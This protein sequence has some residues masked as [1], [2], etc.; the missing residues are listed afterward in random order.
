MHMTTSNR[1][2]TPIA[3]IGVGAIF[4]GASEI[5][6][7]WRNILAG[8]DLITDVPA[9]HW[10]IDDYFDADPTATDKTYGK[11][12][13]FLPA[14]DFDP[15][16]FGVPPNNIG[17]TDTAQ[18]LALIVAQQVLEDACQGEFAAM[19]RDRVSVVLGVA[20]GTELLCSM[21]SRMQRPVWLKALRESGMPEDEAQ[22]ACDR[23]AA[24]YAPWQEATFPGLLGNVVAGRIANRFDLHGTNCVTD[25]AC[26]SSLSA[27][28]MA[29]NELALG[30]SDLVISGGVDT[31]NDIMMY[32]CFSKTPALSASGD[33]RPFSDEADGTMLGEG[34]GMFALKR[35]DDAERDGDRVYAVIRGLGTSSDGRSTAVYAPLPQGQ[36][37]AIANAYAAAGYGPETVELL[38]AHGTGTKAGDAAEFAGLRDVFAGADPARRQ[39]CALGSVK[40]QI[41]HT[42]ATAG[43]AGLLKA[44]LALHHKVLPPTIKIRQPNPKLDIGASPFYLNTQA[45]PWIRNDAHPRRAGVS[46]FGFGGS[47]FHVTVEEYVPASGAQAQPAWRLRAVPTELVLLS[48][49]SAADL[50]RQCRE[51]AAQP[52]ALDA[53]ARASQAAFDAAAPVR[54]ALVAADTAALVQQ[55]GAAIKKIEQDPATPFSTPLG[56]VYGAAKADPGKIAFLFSGQGS[57]YVGMGADLAQHSPAARRAWDLAAQL[58]FDGKPL[59]SVTFPIPVFSDAEREAQAT[60]LTATE[61]AQPALAAQSLAL[62]AEL[63]ELG[64]QP[65]ALAGHSFGELVALHAAGAMSAD[66]LLRLA[67][68][69]GELMRDAGAAPGAMLAVAGVRADIEAVLAGLQIP[70]VVLANHNAPAQVVLSGTTDAIERLQQ[71]LEAQAIQAR[72]LRVAT[73]FHSPLVAQASGPLL[74]FLQGEQ[75]SAPQMPVFANLDGQPYAA[76]AG[77]VAEQLAAQLRM[78]VQ[79]VAQVEAMYASGVR[80]FIEI[81]AG[82]ALT[83]LVGQILGDRPHLAATLDRKNK[84]GVTSLQE[85]IARL[86]VGGVALDF[87]AWWRDYRPA[88]AAPAK[89]PAMAIS[90]SGANHGK[91]YPP[92]GGS[93]ALPPPNPPRP[94]LAVQPAA[95]MPVPVPVPVPTPAP[96]PV[97][98]TAVPQPAPQPIVQQLN[99]QEPIMQQAHVQQPWLDAFEASQRQTADAHAAFQQ[100][101]AESHIAFLKMAEQSSIQLTAMAGIRQAAPFALPAAPAAPAPAPAL[102]SVV[103]VTAVAPVVPVVPVVPVAPVAPVVVVAPVAP[104]AYQA[105]APAAAPAADLEALMLSVV[106]DKTGY[107]TEMLGME[108]QLEADL[109]IDSIKRVEILSALR[110]LAPGLAD[111]S[112]AELGKLRTLGEIVAHMRS[113]G[114]AAAPAPAPAAATVVAPAADLEALMLSVVADKTGYPTE[115]LGMEMQLEADLGIDSIKRVEILSALRELAPGLADISPAELGKLRTLGEIVAHM[116]ALGGAAAPA[117]A[118]AP[119]VAPVVAPAPAPAAAPAAADLEA[120]MLSVVADKTGYPTEMLGMEMQL[121]A[122]LG[123]DSIKRVEILSALRELAP[124]LADIS[125]A[126]LGKL[127]TLGEIVAHMRAQDAA[128]SA[129]NTDATSSATPPAAQRFALRMLPAAAPGQAMPGL[130]SPKLVITEDGQGVAALLAAQ[131]GSRGI[132]A[133]VVESVPA[134]ASGVIFLGGLRDCAGIDDAIGINHAAF[135]AARAV[136][137]SFEQ[138]GGLFVAVQDTGGDFGLSGRAQDRA[139]SGGAAALVRTAAR[140]WPL[141]TL[142]VIDCERAARTAEALAAAICG[143]LLRGGADAEVGLRANAARAT[144]A[145]L[146]AAVQP[147]AQ[148][149]IDRDS[150]LVVTGGARGVTAACLVALAREHQPRLVLI[151][152]TELADEPASLRGAAD[153]ASLKTAL[154]AHLQ[155]DGKPNPAQVNAELARLLAAREIRATLDALAQAGSEV[156]YLAV[157]VQDAAALQAG[158]AGVRQAWGPVTGI[159]HGAG[160]LADRRIVDKTDAQFQQ[161]FHT[162]V[163]GL[164]ALLDATAQDPLSTICL[165]SSIAANTGNVGQSDYAMANEVLN[166]VACSERARRADCLVRSIGWGPW[167]GGMVS[168]ALAAHFE[169]EG[170][171]LLALDEGTRAFVDELGASLDDVPVLVLPAAAGAGALGAPADQPIQVSYTVAEA[172]HGYLGDHAIAGTPVVPVAM[173]LEWLVRTARVWHPQPG[174]MTLRHVRVLRRIALADFSQGGVREVRARGILSSESPH[175]SLA[176]ELADADHALH[177]R[178][179]AAPGAAVSERAA[180]AEPDRLLPFQRPQVYDGHVLFHGPRF[181]AIERLEGHAAHGAVATLVGAARLGWQDDD[182]QTDPALVDG[183]LQLAVLWAETLLGGASLPMAVGEL[184]L[185]RTGLA[186]G[187]VR[188]AVR[189]LE[190]HGERASC[191]ISFVDADG[192]VRAELLQ[193]DLIL[194]P[195][196]ANRTLDQA[197]A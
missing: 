170:V 115:M 33:C 114:G 104:A 120:L 147:A 138:R 30:Q 41:G 31:L 124:G 182:W 47:N 135:A 103:P 62:L 109:G 51:L 43:A 58:S 4:P 174:P 116:R 121:E 90:L 177:Y 176:L 142:K 65:S 136:A 187:P 122:D 1:Q 164:R 196:A 180:G 18:L 94:A 28:N 82:A 93:A 52:P 179:I 132:A 59:H 137:A 133:T 146:P 26:A 145:R 188:C 189:A 107:P 87:D 8:K 23:I 46:S 139:W 191:D 40:S 149:R 77:V 161:V 97:A 27:L 57:Q 169:R 123:I 29:I 175:P 37:R 140:E 60:L 35:L 126:E 12:G 100:A 152:R 13:G 81:G 186:A 119:T 99:M 162:K 125:P 151:G 20:S 61:W 71:A 173:A 156:R 96:A 167:Q 49:P 70:D 148:A 72:R 76:D 110:E 88:A 21:A 155:A 141:A 54:L 178:A 131:L 73:A 48:A 113:L 184:R 102:A 24:H 154:I 86:S 128:P 56:M 172:S 10:L 168:P 181:Q 14:V 117:P 50:L 74:A 150:V 75:L 112:P 25:A 118:A 84:H 127:R 192:A 95:A 111:I 144:L 193:V 153:P 16:G 165:F 197:A 34:L 160:V 2:Q 64:L 92:P 3:V 19:P 17:A 194:R 36:A 68:Q 38:E 39:W 53:A 106:A 183:G 143:E 45:R 129:N 5:G 44:V 105:P 66:T 195:D 98:A 78:P 185:H 190:V 9:S 63:A 89:K 101:M 163:G 11:R 130:A 32:M 134:D 42:K 22:A 83:D 15:M 159:V 6:G 91:P 79:F 171:A 108:M 85:G 157:D 7:F 69:R 55:L 80:T 166:Q 158:L 67:R